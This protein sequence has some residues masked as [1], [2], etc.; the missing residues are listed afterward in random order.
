MA[1]ATSS[2]SSARCWASTGTP[3]Q[4]W[5]SA[6]HT[7]FQLAQTRST[8]TPTL[9]RPLCDASCAIARTRWS[10]CGAFHTGKATQRL[11]CRRLRRLL[12]RRPGPWTACCSP[13]P[14]L[15]T[16]RSVWTV[17]PR[18]TTGV[19]AAAAARTAGS[20]SLRAGA[21]AP[22]KTPSLCSCQSP[23]SH[24]SQGVVAWGRCA[25]LGT[26]VPAP[27]KCIW[28]NCMYISMYTLH[29]THYYGMFVCRVC[30]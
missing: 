25:G 17:A 8:T 14:Q 16:A 21:G 10:R 27:Y 26:A 24:L 7:R 18:R 29:I 28:N 15:A 2:F 20:S 4:L 19:L 1:P 13:T 6:R 11:C 22:L 3:V 5:P 30:M 9:R 23:C 12:L